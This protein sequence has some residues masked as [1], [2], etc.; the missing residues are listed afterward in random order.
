MTRLDEI[1]AKIEAG[2]LLTYEDAADIFEHTVIGR[3][4]DRSRAEMLEL[5]RGRFPT[6]EAL[7]ANI[8]GSYD[9]FNKIMRNR[10]PKPH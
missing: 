7:S 2:E 1:E 4:F 9:A 5:L 10:Q 3:G 8:K 6:V